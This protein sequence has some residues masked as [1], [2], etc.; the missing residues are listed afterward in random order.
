MSGTLL[1]FYFLLFIFPF[2]PLLTPIHNL[3]IRTRLTLGA[4]LLIAAIS[5]FVFIYFPSYLADKQL[6]ALG[7]KA[8]SIANTTA[9]SIGPAL[10]FE[11]PISAKQVINGTRQ[12]QDLAYIIVLNAQDERFVSYNPELAELADYQNIQNAISTDGRFYNTQTPIQLIEEQSEQIGQLF[13]GLSLDAVNIQVRQSR[14]VIAIV[15]LII[16]IFGIGG[17]ILLSTIITNPLTQMVQTAQQIAAGDLSQRAQVQSTDEVGHLAHSFNQMVD[18]LAEAQQ[19]LEKRVEERTQELQTTNNELLQAKDAAE[20]ANRAKS[21]FL[22][23]MSHELRTPLNAILG[24][25]QLMVRDQSPSNEHRDNL[26]VVSR[27][28]EHLLSLINDVLE[29][30]KI[31]AGQTILTEEAFDLYR[32]L[33]DVKGMFQLRAEDKNLQLIFEYIEEVPQYVYLDQGKLRQVLINLLNNAI[34]FTE[35]GGVTLRAKIQDAHLLFEVEDTGPGIAPEEQRALFE[36]FSQT[37]TGQKSQEGTGLGL[38][39]SQQ[40]VSLMQGE[41]SV[42][43]NVGRGST[44]SFHVV[45]KNATAEDIQPTNQTNHNVVGIAP[46]QPTYRILI[47]EDRIE[48]RKLLTRFLTP[49]GFEVREAEDGKV[50]LDVWNEWKPHLIWMDMRMPVMDGYEATKRIKAADEDKETVI[51]ALTASVFEEER[52]IVLSIGCDDFVRKPFKPQDIY[53]A[54]TKHLGIEFIYEDDELPVTEADSEAAISGALTQLSA[55]WISTFHEAAN[56][57]DTDEMLTLLS[58]IESDHA[59]AVKELTDMV[60]NFRLEELITL[61]QP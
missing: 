35:K 56:R 43:S 54:L 52:S 55:E 60:N 31:E 19:T 27:S 12:N 2:M 39:I 18:N 15:S 28:G 41:F 1:P 9:F 53:D 22:A 38:S 6:H 11:D 30:S 5:I 48:N 25:T 37:E 45:H 57:A 40:F 61:T 29:I 59:N 24:F 20:T 34:K 51:I 21:A 10:V 16:F 42:H 23:N 47:V 13:L 3:A 8:Q 7:E 33:N 36:A 50:G 46:G 17:V 58:Q 32:L 26:S 14:E 4:S 44:F 49:L